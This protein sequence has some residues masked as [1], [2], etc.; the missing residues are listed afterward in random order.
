MDDDDERPKK[1]RNPFS[2]KTF[3]KK[4]EGGE[5]HEDDDDHLATASGVGSKA[6]TK[7]HS[8]WP[9]TARLKTGLEMEETP[10]PEVEN[11]G[12][13]YCRP[14]SFFSY[15]YTWVDIF[16]HKLSVCKYLECIQCYSQCIYCNIHYSSTSL[17]SSVCEVSSWPL[18]MNWNRV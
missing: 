1:E 5:S 16:Q 14:I 10:F 11:E 7:P 17:S 9:S 12:I 3:I 4:K 15:T 6:S 2:F 8:Q 18:C 13:V